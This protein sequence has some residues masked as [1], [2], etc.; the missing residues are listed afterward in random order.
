VYAP[1][2]AH[3]TEV[4]DAAVAPGTR[5]PAAAVTALAPVGRP[6]AAER[7][8]SDLPA[9]RD[10]L[11]TP[12]D[13][14]QEVRRQR[15]ARLVAGELRALIDSGC[16]PGDVMVL[17]RTRAS[18]R[19][20]AAEL[21]VVHVPFAAPEATPLRE[22]SQV[23]DLLAV[24]DVL[25]SPSHDLSLAH[26]LRSPLFGASD[27]DLQQVAEAAAR[28][29]A[30]WWPALFE[31]VDAH[32]TLVRARTLLARWR[33]AAAWLPP[34]DLLDRIVA[35]G[36]ARVRFAAAV[37]AERRRSALAAVDALL[38][39]SLTLDGAR[40][41]TPYGF[42]RALRRRSIAACGVNATDAVALL[43]V[44]GAKGLEAHTVFLMDCDSE[45]R[46]A[47]TSTLLVDW[48]VQ[49]AAPARVAFVAHE[50]QLAPSLRTLLQH[51]RRE[52]Q[53]EELNALYVAMTRASDRLVLSRTLAYKPSTDAWW[54]RLQE[55]AVDA[56][57]T[58]AAAHPAHGYR[59]AA[60]L[61]V[62]ELPALP[63]AVQAGGA[64]PALCAD[65]AAA[66]VG[67][68]VHRVLEW[69]SG[70]RGAGGDAPLDALARAAA[71][72]AGVPPDAVDRVRR[73]SATILHAPACQ[74]FFGGRQL[75]WSANEWV[76][77]DG[78]QPLRADR[79]VALGEEAHDEA[80]WQWWVLDYK[81]HHHPDELT[82]YRAQLRRYRDLLR[83]LVPAGTVR[84]AFVTGAGE[85]IEPD[86]DA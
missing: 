42:V 86:L 1:F 25:A 11:T 47:A 56:P 29:G 4:A 81:L 70:P 13:R 38:E 46:S 32:A 54:P 27:D 36:D 19:R 20:L 66:A 61:R 60:T 44:H 74:A 58:A 40:Y 7:P 64:A 83:A 22:A 16:A 15:E 12:R 49:A 72:Q 51:E 35:E 84:A 31:L 82:P 8:A 78:D 80:N 33:D 6:D 45:A 68:A 76:L 10:S 48:P 73:I 5:L 23:R 2:R 71:R 28:S 37:P 41:L 34:H 59:E 3:T 75:R 67:L 69:A 52:Q 50:A 85:C 21:Q 26:A 57:P 39:Q 18:L 79:V 53:R 62:L 14:A 17:A 24:L 43:T 55:V 30:G 77:Y 63:A 65:D 9:W